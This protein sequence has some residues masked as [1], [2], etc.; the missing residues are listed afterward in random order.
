M[1][2]KDAIEVI[3]N[4]EGMTKQDL[5][6]KLGITPGMVSHYSSGDHYPRLN[7][8]A[9]LYRLYKVQ[10]EP[11]TLLSLSDEMDRQIEEELS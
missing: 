7:V 2:V 8:A 6:A 5:A 4:E 3:M 11:F 10:V 9:K 1:F